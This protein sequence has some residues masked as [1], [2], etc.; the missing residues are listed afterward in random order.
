L[1]NNV[2]SNKDYTLTARADE[3][4]AISLGYGDDKNNIT[5]TIKGSGGEKIISPY[6]N[7]YV[8]RGVTLILDE[9]I[10]CHNDN[11]NSNCIENFGTL[12]MNTGAKLSRTITGS[13][14]AVYISPS[15]TFTMNGGE[16][17]GHN[18]G[19]GITG[20][21]T[22]IM[23]GGEISGN[24]VGVSVDGTF[25][26]NNGTISGN[27]SRGV[28]VS[29]GTFTMNGGE[30]SG[31]GG[32]VSITG[33][34]TFIMNDGT[35]SGNTSNG[36]GGGVYLNC[37]GYRNGTFTMNGGKIS[38]NTINGNGD[39]GG[40]YVYSYGTFTMNGG[41]IS[42]NK[43]NAINNGGYTSYNSGGGIY[44]SLYSIFRISNGIV[45]GSEADE[46]KANIAPTQS[47]Y[48]NTIYYG[49]SLRKADDGSTAQYGTGD[50][51]NNIPLDY[52]DRTREATI[53]VI[54]GVLQ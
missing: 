44:M 43:V 50:T 48:G 47:H 33:N 14:S 24:E 39:G 26:M 1:R 53:N 19:V 25:T 51:W 4:V 41:E 35:I 29:D 6:T 11:V 42:G 22:F 17:S 21:G 34:G 12:V 38:G 8:G 49:S 54:N 13:R 28:G 32:G 31:N 3:T 46:D 40:V 16:I 2:Q 45:Y 20:N 10:T 15:A 27:T 18:L 52:D 9:N 5:I 23:N 7:V 37:S 30:I 36:S